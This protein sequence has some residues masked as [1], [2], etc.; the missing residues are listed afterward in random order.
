MLRAAIRRQP[1]PENEPATVRSRLVTSQVCLQFGD[2]IFVYDRI[3]MFIYINRSINHGLTSGFS[4]CDDVRD[5]STWHAAAAEL[6][7]HNRDT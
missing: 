2:R 5:V 1:L 7:N 6:P 4:S 3:I